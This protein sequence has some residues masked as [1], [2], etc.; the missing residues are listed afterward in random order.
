MLPTPTLYS[1]G[2]YRVVA[3]EPG[4]DKSHH[5]VVMDTAGAR[6][7]D[8]TTFDAA[9][10]WVDACLDAGQLNRQPARGLPA[11]RR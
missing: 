7:R 9:R 1:R 10:A 5:F 11:R 3:S 2:P 6:L 4:A 8:E